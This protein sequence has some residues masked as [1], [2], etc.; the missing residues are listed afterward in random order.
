MSRSPEPCCA[1]CRHWLRGTWRIWPPDMMRRDRW[2]QGPGDSFGWQLDLH[3]KAGTTEWDPVE[4]WD[5]HS[6]EQNIGECQAACDGI[7]IATADGVYGGFTT[8]ETFSC[9]KFEPYADRSEQERTLTYRISE[10]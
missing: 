6:D 5:V 9:S 2:G 7:S 8:D 1:L 3:P 4:R 10:K